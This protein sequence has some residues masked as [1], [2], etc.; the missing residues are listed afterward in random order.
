MQ[1]LPETDGFFSPVADPVPSAKVV[2]AL[3]YWAGD[4]DKALALAALMADIE[5]APRTDVI[6]VISHRRGSEPPDTDLVRLISSKFPNFVVVGGVRTG[7][8]HPQGCN[9]LWV[10]TVTAI[11]QVSHLAK[12]AFTTEADVIP[13]RRD[14]INCLK[15]EMVALD[16]SGKLIS[17]HWQGGGRNQP[18]HI[19]G[20]MLVHTNITRLIP[21]IYSIPTHQ[22]WDVWLGQFF[23][24]HWRKGSW[25]YNGYIGGPKVN[26]WDS[27]NHK[28]SWTPDEFRRLRGAGY[29]LVHGVRDKSG[30]EFVLSE[31]G[32]KNS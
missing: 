6:F 4:R 14:W 11:G 24:P 27:P 13:L 3:Q 21:M 15:V 29:A 31:W 32:S 12:Y 25:I 26:P 18:D 23:R 1:S 9:D 10:D 16:S 5:P 22:A 17:G 2:I 20:N 28:G 8:G 7:T 30:I 19:N